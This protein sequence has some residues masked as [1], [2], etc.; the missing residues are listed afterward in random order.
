MARP[1]DTRAAL[2]VA[3]VAAGLVVVLAVIVALDPVSPP[4]LQ[5]LDDAWRSVV[6]PPPAWA[7]DLARAFY[8]A[9]AGSVAAPFRVGV[10]AVLAVRR[11][12]LELAAW[13]LGW[14]LADAL[15][16]VLK[17][18]L[19]RPRPDGSDLTSFPS[20]HTKTAAQI[21][22]GLALLVPAMVRIRWVVW[23]AALAVVVG[24]AWSRTVLDHH[25]LSDTVGGGCLGAACAVAA[26]WTM[27][28]LGQAPGQTPPADQA[29][30]EGTGQAP[31]Q[32]P[33]AALASS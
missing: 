20:G 13:L 31:G 18:A 6:Q 11:R 12:W 17:P 8:V 24:M 3:A 27:R 23:G 9:G 25:W 15:T 26:V 1:D 7:H 2:S 28:R 32:T 30:G 14:A 33:P 21:A 10:A 29:P 4:L 16:Q 22:V 5:P 19:D